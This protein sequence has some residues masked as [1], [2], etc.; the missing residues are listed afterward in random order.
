MEVVAAIV[1]LS[2]PI[3]TCMGGDATRGTEQQPEGSRCDSLK[4]HEWLKGE[5]EQNPRK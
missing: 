2:C 4:W 3:V 5:S 1:P